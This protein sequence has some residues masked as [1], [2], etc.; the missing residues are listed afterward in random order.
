MRIADVR[1]TPIAFRDP[2]LLNVAGCHEPWAVRS[3]IE[4]ETDNGLVGLGESY[5]EDA[6]LADLNAIA[7]KLVGLDPFDLNALARAVYARFADLG[8]AAAAFPA[9][10][11]KARASALG[12]FEVP[13]LDLQGQ[14]TKRPLYEILGGAVRENVSYSAYLFYKF[15]RHKDDPGY[16]QDSWG[17]GLTH[18]QMVAQAKRMIDEYGFG[19]IKLKAGVFDPEFEIETLRALRDAFP[20]YPLRIDPNGGWSVETT[21]RLMPK[22]T[23]LLEYLEDPAP[24]LQDMGE[25]AKFATMPLATNMV[26]IAFGHIPETI[27]LNA[28]QVVLTD[29]HYWGGLRATQQLAHLGRVFGFG[30]SMHSNSHMGISLAAMTHVGATIPNLTYA[31][32]THY[33]WQEDEVIEGGKLAIRGG[34]LA[35]PAGHGLG[36]KL[37]RA[38]LKR[39]HQNWLDCGIRKRDDGKEMRKHQPDWK[40]DRP[41]F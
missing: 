6:T 4:I 5:G 14:A 11:D 32:D 28:V 2:P 21:R 19:S 39:L 23:G 12:A 13:F 3:I 1:I 22:L 15:A 37:D 35:P 24:T 8:D 27:R 10:G 26:T 31:C 34:A 33:P 16:P 30:V 36:V 38:A 29:H 17:E 18:Q 7:P 40:G 9:K 25:V 41:R 20:G